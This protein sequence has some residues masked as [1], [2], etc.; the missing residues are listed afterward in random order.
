MMEKHAISNYTSEKI[1]RILSKADHGAQK[2]LLAE[3]R[4]GVGKE[5]GELPM[6]WGTL[7][8]GIP[9]ELTSLSGAASAAEWSIYTALTLFA[10][11]QQ[12]HD[13]QS[14]PMHESGKSFGSAV[15][16]LAPTEE[17][18][19]R[20]LRRFNMLAT[21]TERTETSHHLRGIV[22]L[23]SASGI[24]LDYGALAENL[25]WYQFPEAQAK[26]RLLWGQ[27]FYRNRKVE[28]HE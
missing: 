4:R 3:L 15:A 22:Q 7:L 10:L 13:P 16:A 25:Y 12:G 1:A 21:S 14:E 6:L 17:E 8:E 2:A 26:V 23:L 11:H 20:V 28:E 24:P 19:D 18:Q 5:P 9:Q 27:D